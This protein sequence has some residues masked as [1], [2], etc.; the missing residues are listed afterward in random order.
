[1]LRL[2]LGDKVYDYD[3]AQPLTAGDLV[4]LREM[5]ADPEKWVAMTDWL[6]DG[7]VKGELS[8]GQYVEMAEALIQVAYLAAVRADHSLTWREFIWTLPLDTDQWNVEIVKA[9]ANRA[10]R[11]ATAKK[12]KK[13]TA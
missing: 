12:A 2:T 6:A 4:A 1:M 7:Q 8:Q 3:D 9:P 11:R 13:A 5:G 10:G